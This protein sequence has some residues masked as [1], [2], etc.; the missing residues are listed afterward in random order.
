M[1]A[2]P[3]KPTLS[4]DFRGLHANAEGE[5]LTEPLRGVFEV[6]SGD[7]KLGTVVAN[8]EKGRNQTLML[9]TVKDITIRLSWSKCP[10]AT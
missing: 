9:Q 3:S 6:W 7:T 4:V 8:P 10:R 1:P 2:W 5:W